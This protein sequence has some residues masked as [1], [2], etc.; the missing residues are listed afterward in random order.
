MF[1]S[2][3]RVYKALCDDS[4]FIPLMPIYSRVIH[5]FWSPVHETSIVTVS[6]VTFSS[7]RVLQ[8]LINTCITDIFSCLG[9]LDAAFIKS[10]SLARLTAVFHPI[11]HHYFCMSRDRN[12][13]SVFAHHS[14]KRCLFAHICTYN[15]LVAFFHSSLDLH[16]RGYISC[17][18]FPHMDFIA[19]LILW[20]S[21]FGFNF[22]PI[23][24]VEYQLILHYFRDQETRCI[25][26]NSGNCAILDLTFAVIF[27]SYIK[28]REFTNT[29]I[30]V[31]DH[32][33]AIFIGDSRHSSPEFAREST[34]AS[35]SFLQFRADIFRLIVIPL[36][37]S[38]SYWWVVNMNSWTLTS[39][40][41]VFIF[42]QFC[43]RSGCGKLGMIFL[44]QVRLWASWRIIMLQ[45][46]LW[47]SLRIIL[48]QVRLWDNYCWTVDDLPVSG[49]DEEQLRVFA[50]S[51]QPAEQ[52][53]H[54][55]R[56]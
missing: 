39:I 7:R 22:N 42:L 15:G 19:K 1:S 30:R 54:Q 18:H 55:V 28:W 52:L 46:R 8:H 10:T 51:G 47:A 34:S 21:H 27:L 24:Q 33:P 45:V 56:L 29:R 3:I 32:S 49:Q 48:L 35:A 53:L 44:C 26:F 9:F 37:S 43:F 41:S 31:R 20:S 25:S 50:V 4:K 11:T 38:F 16:T 6:L 40:I 36:P 14:S 13:S 23:L 2:C 5:I 12:L 17:F